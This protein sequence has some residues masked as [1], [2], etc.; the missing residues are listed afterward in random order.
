MTTRIIQRGRVVWANGSGF[1]PAAHNEEVVSALLP[2]EQHTL[3]VGTIWHDSEDD[4]NYRIV[5][6]GVVTAQ[7]GW[8]TAD[9]WIKHLKAQW[10]IFRELVLR[11]CFDAAVEDGTGS[12]RYRMLDPTKTNKQLEKIRKRNAA[13][14]FG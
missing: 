11:G 13:R 10:H 12:R 6:K 5:E 7:G 14:R 8:G 9:F 1:K 2:S 4:L 3:R